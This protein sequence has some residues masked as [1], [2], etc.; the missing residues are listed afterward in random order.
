MPFSPLPFAALALLP[1]LL[2]LPISA[3][4]QGA[5]KGQI[6]GQTKTAIATIVGMQNGDNACYLSLKD[7]AGI[8]FSEMADFEFCRRQGA[9]VG[10]RVVLT[11]QPQYVQSPECQGDPR[12]AKRQLVP[13]VV[14]AKPAAASR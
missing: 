5:G 1:G 10:Q 6:D 14:D 7:D 2:V 11:Y 3:A 8:A 12:C 13:L 9:L 4:A